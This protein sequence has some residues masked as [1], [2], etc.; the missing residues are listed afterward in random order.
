[1]TETPRIYVACLAA[2]NNG[3][4]HG[5]WIDANQDAEDLQ[6]AVQKMLSQSP[7]PGAEE[8]AIHDYEAFDG[9]EIHESESFETVSALARFIEEQLILQK[10]HC[11]QNCMK[12]YQNTLSVR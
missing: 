9:V 10:T 6:K 3:K 12:D 8:W 5:A 11:R 4:L 7:E 2:Y 1:M